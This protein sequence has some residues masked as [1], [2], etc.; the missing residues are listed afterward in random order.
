MK[1]LD[2]RQNQIL[3]FL[4]LDNLTPH[5]I[6]AATGKSLESIRLELGNALLALQSAMTIRLMQPRT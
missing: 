5:Q 2:S 6:A 1:S 4:F 3:G